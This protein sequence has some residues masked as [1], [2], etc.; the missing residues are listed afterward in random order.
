MYV[1]DTAKVQHFPPAREKLLV[2]MLLTFAISFHLLTKGPPWPTLLSPFLEET[3][4]LKI[5]NKVYLLIVIERN[6]GH[7]PWAQ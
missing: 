4:I 3:P 1:R 2:D 7:L 5:R 6:L